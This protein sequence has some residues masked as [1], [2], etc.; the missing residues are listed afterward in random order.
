MTNVGDVATKKNV[1]TIDQILLNPLDVPQPEQHF[2]KAPASKFSCLLFDLA[3][4]DLVAGGIVG[5]LAAVPLIIFAFIYL[6]RRRRQ[7]HDQAMMQETKSLST[8]EDAASLYATPNKFAFPTTFSTPAASEPESPR[9]SR[10]WTASSS[11][12]SVHVVSQA[13]EAED[14]LPPYQS[15]QPKGHFS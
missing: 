4:R 15:D 2:S 3:N 7:K 10:Q 9:E 11:A 8:V 12:P 6:R 14:L 1:M 13:P 5:S